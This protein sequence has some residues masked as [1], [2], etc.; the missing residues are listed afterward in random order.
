LRIDVLPNVWIPLSDGCRLA[1]RLWLPNDP[2][3]LPVPAVL[4]YLPYRKDDANANQDSTRNPYFAEHGYAAIRVDIRGTGDSDGILLDEYTRQEQDDAL[5]V[6][7]WIAEQTW[8]TGD[9]GMI[10]YSWGG[11][12]GLQ[13][14]ARRPPQLKAVISGYSTDDRYA[15]DCHYM[16]GCLLG[17]DMLKWATS[18]RVYNALPPDPRF[19]DDW[20]EVWLTRLAETPP[21]IESWLTHQLRDGFW[22]Q[23]SIAEDYAA[24]E[25]ATLLVGGWADAYTN[26]VPRMLEHLTCPRRGLIGPWAHFLPYLDGTPG[27]RIGFLQEC[28]RW[29]DRWLKG[30]DTGVDADPLLRVWMQGSVEPSDTYAERPGRWLAIREWPAPGER[31]ARWSLRSDGTLVAE[32]AEPSGSRTQDATVSV[33]SPQHVGESAGVWCANGLGHELAL[34]QRSDDDLCAHFDSEPLDGPLEVIG[35]PQVSLSVRADRAAALVAVRLCEVAADGASTLVSW[36]L[37]NLTH[38]D[39]H[40]RASALEPGREYRVSVKLNVVGHRFSAG[41]RLRVSI[42]PTYWPHAWPS[43]EAVTLTVRLD[44]ES[45]LSLPVPDAG[46]IAGASVDPTPEGSR[47]LDP[48]ATHSR[49]REI[50]RGDDGLHTIEDTERG[51]ET[52]ADSGTRLE[53]L[54][55]DAYRIAEDDPLSAATESRREW[56][57]HRD[58][59]HVRVVARGS[60]HCDAR[61]FFVDDSLEARLDAEQVFSAKRR[62]EV[63]RIGT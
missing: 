8:C 38:R 28:L 30:I 31:R 52:I 54:S 41:N 9:V 33:G 2:A 24:I 20:R 45:V 63:P 37:L 19:R 60:M 39:G 53:G 27:P 18:M 15:D 50:R 26:A 46:S 13:I 5:E 51:S 29:F 22:K 61:T 62:I 12:N 40:E 42:S 4:E 48:G 25:A 36:G 44:G 16:G 17:S 49:R 59:W 57:L 34:D 55:I 21:F 6:L 32:T 1:A 3:A 43:P 10:G 7:A 11:F 35:F 47:P 14:A 56:E 23:G 58:G